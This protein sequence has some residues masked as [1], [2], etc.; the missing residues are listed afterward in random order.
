W[1]AFCYVRDLASEA[2]WSTAWQ[3]SLRPAENYEA[4]FSEGRAEFRRRDR[5]S[6]NDP[7]IETHTEIVVSPEDDIELRRVAI[8]NRARRRRTLELTTY[9]E[10]VLAPPAADAMHPAFSHLFVQTEFLESPSAI[11]CTRRPRSPEEQTPWMCHLMGVHAARSGEVSHETDRARFLGRGNGL[12]SP[13]AMRRPGP[14]SGS[15]GSVLDPIAA[16]RCTITL[17]GDESATID[18]VTGIASS[19]DACVALVEKYVDRRLT[20]RVFKLAWSHS[21]VVLR[22][23]GASEIEAQLYARL[24][25]SIVYANPALRADAPVLMRNRRGQADLWAHGISGD[26]PIVLVVVSENSHLALVR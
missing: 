4:I 3:P 13:D 8:T 23:L 21:Q 20:D 2:F 12:S 26:F 24:A 17:D 6:A 10:S 15:C 9:A 11:L 22:Q 1:G 18:I 14:L 5:V 16:S 19:R 25:S 7:G